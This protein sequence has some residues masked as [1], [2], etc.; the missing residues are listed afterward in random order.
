M[1][2]TKW[3]I[4]MNINSSD[5]QYKTI[6]CQKLSGKTK[7]RKDDIHPAVCGHFPNYEFGDYR[8]RRE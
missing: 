4:Y 3:F 8:P 6:A 1:G 5:R 2:K 7:N